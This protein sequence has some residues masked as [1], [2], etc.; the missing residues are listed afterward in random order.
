[1][2]TTQRHPRRVAVST[3]DSNAAVDQ[4]ASMPELVPKSDEIKQHLVDALRAHPLFEHLALP[5]MHKCID[6][7]T[8][9]SYSAG[10]EVIR[11]GDA[12]DQ[13]YVV[14]AG[15]F[16][17]Y[18]DAGSS[19][20]PSNGGAVADG[21]TGTDAG[22][23][24]S[25]G[26]GSGEYLLQLYGYGE[27]FGELALLYNAP[28]ACSVR[29]TSD[30]KAFA[31]DRISF[32]QLVM[33]HNSGVKYGLE[34]YLR[35]VPLLADLQVRPAGQTLGPRRAALNPMASRLSPLLSSAVLSSALLSS[36]AARVLA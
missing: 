22:H 28:R 23:P 12:G 32:R 35:T 30:S 19:K 29:A 17:A 20:N 36:C 6:A 9:V 2:T 31:L 16:E 33:Q 14:Y 5:L 25:K 13:F 24:T 21:S 26:A 15:N 18:H 4:N 27:V 8:E 1:M 10:D 3:E 7:T 34:K 11:E